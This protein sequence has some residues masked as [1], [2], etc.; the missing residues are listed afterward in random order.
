[1]GNDTD[2]ETASARLANGQGHVER[3][4]KR[5]EGT[6][7]SRTDNQTVSDSDDE[8]TRA[9]PKV[10]LHKNMKPKGNAAS[11]RNSTWYLF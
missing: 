7:Q 11:C 4:K 8:L 1:M 3:M 9:K 6:T 2:D 5:Y 10:K